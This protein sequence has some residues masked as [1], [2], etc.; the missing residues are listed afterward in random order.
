MKKQY[1]EEFERQKKEDEAKYNLER[2]KYLE[3]QKRLQL[4]VDMQKNN[5]QKLGDE[6]EQKMQES[7]RA[8]EQ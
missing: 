1:E 3:D 4:E 7:Q 8:L 2:E 5:K 6:M